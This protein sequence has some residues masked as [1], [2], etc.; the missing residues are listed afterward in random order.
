MARIST[1]WIYPIKSLDGVAVPEVRVLPSGALAGDRE[2]ALVDDRDRFINGKRNA[3][4][5]GVTAKFDV[6]ARTVSLS[7]RGEPSTA[8]FHLDTERSHLERWFS[9]FFQQTVRLVCNAEVGFP[10]DTVSPGPTVVAEATLVAVA[11][12]YADLEFKHIRQRFRTNVEIADVPAFWEDRLYG[13]DD[14]TVPFRLGGVAFTGVNPCQRCIVPARHPLTGAPYPNFQRTFVAQRRAHLPHW[15]A[16]DR[17]N[18]YY[19]LTANT[20]LTDVDGGII[21]TNDEVA[22]I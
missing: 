21:C 8:T 2:F 18:H 17:F 1:I 22:L 7:K 13:S 20:R 9:Q 4:I 11:A 10:D 15:A 19:R 5:H 14:L 3:V 16:V 6:K 12:W